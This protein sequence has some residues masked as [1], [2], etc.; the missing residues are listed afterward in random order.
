MPLAT[1]LNT[2]AFRNHTT[3]TMPMTPR[4]VGDWTKLS[5]SGTMQRWLSGLEDSEV[6]LATATV[7]IPAG[8]I[9]LVETTPDGIRL[10]VPRN[11]EY[12]EIVSD[13]GDE[14]S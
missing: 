11:D 3:Y 6:V 4:F 14:E 13:G 9:V 12:T 1:P 8:V 10:S 7:A 5:D 2:F